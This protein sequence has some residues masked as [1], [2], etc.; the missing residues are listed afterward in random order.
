MVRSYVTSV[1]NNDEYAA[2]PPEIFQKI[3]TRNRTFP[4]DVYVALDT[5]SDKRVLFF[6]RVK[7]TEYIGADNKS[8]LMLDNMNKWQS[9]WRAVFERSPTKTFR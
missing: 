6:S 2:R 7:S 1:F 9:K 5:L 8:K 3:K 4:V